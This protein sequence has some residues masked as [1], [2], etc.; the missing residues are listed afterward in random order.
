MAVIGMVLSACGNA[1]IY[2]LAEPGP[3][4]PGIR[5][6]TFFDPARGG[7]EVNISVWYPAIQPEGYTGTVSRDA[8]PVRD[9]APYPLILSSNKV[10]R[11]FAAHMVSH[12]FVYVGVDDIDT[13]E[14][15]DENLVDQPLDLLFALE[16]VAYPQLEGMDGMIDAERTGVMGYSFDG[17]NALALSGAR[18][19]PEYYLSQCAQVATMEPPLS[20]WRIWYFCNLATRWNAFAAHAGE[21]LTASDDGLWQ[22]I[23]DERILAVMPMGPEGAWLFGERGLAAVDRPILIIVGAED[24]ATPYETEAVYIY[25]H[26][27]TPDKTLVS[28]V[29]EGHM[30]IYDDAQ[31]LRMKH[32]ALG[33]F[34]YHLQGQEAYT[35]QFSR[36]FVFWQEGLTWGVVDK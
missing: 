36:W 14:P 27:G 22:P 1:S 19:D 18:I 15:W 2:P 24:T 12:G 8:E 35:R 25:E 21:G 11:L 32:F 31:V 20:E 4:F 16:Q 23:T 7:R 9:G 5:A 26:L 34:G 30:M 10:G 17:Y 29:G 33:F 6:Y 3:Y 13:Y 28:V